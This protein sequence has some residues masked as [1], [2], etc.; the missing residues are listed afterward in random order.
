MIYTIGHSTR[1]EREFLG[2]LHHHSISMLIDIRTIPRSRWNPQFDKT[3]LQNSVTEAG[4]EYLHI[5]EL[6]GLRKPSAESVN[7]AWK[8]PGFR[9]YADYM[10]TAAF[11]EALLKVIDFGWKERIAL[12]CAEA[13]YAKCHRMLVSDAL[14]AR[15]VEVLHIVNA[16]Q[17]KSHTLSS[18]ARLEGKKV[19]YPLDQSKLEF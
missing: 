4:M 1:S 13:Y 18:F 2:M 17:V 8:N 12:M 7:L 11:E 10:Q 14:V 15:G 9:G 5:P 16:N 19:T 3:T 6:G